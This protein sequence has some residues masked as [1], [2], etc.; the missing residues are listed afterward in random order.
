MPYLPI[1]VT[2]DPEPATIAY[3][4]IGYAVLEKVKLSVCGVGDCT[5]IMM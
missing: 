1:M 4:N 5:N 2:N 3:I